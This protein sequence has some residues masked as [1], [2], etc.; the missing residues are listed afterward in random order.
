MICIY[1]IT[2]A[3]FL[4]FIGYSYKRFSQMRH[5]FYILFFC[6]VALNNI[7]AQI[8]P[9]T[10]KCVQNDTIR[11]EPFNN[12]CGAFQR[13]LIYGSMSKDGPY[14]Q[15]ASITNFTVNNYF[16]NHPKNENWFYFMQS[17]YDC[18][19]QPLINSDTLDG[20]SP[21]APIIQSVSVDAKNITI[22][23]EASKDKRVSGYI[24]YKQTDFGVKPIDTV[25]SSTKFIDT[26]VNPDKKRESYYVLGINKCGG[27]SL[28]GKPHQS[29]QL[30]VLQDECERAALLRW[31][32]YKD[33]DKGI[34]KHEVWMREGNQPY[35]KVDSVSAKDTFFIYKGLKDKTKYCF[36]VKSIQKENPK[37]V[38][39]TNEVCI[40]GNVVKTTEFIVIKNLEVNKNGEASFTWIWNNDADLDSIKIKRA[41]DGGSYKEISSLPT[42]NYGAEITFSDKT[43]LDNKQLN[44][45]EIYSLDIC[46]YYTIARFPTILLEGKPLDN[47]SNNIS[48]SPHFIDE[49]S[50]EYEL[51]RVV[52]NIETKIWEAKNE[53]DFTDP[54]DPLNPDN[55]IICYYVVSY[56]YDTLPNG[57]PIR[58]RSKSNTTCVSQTAGLF[59]PNAF[60]PRGVNQEFRPLISFNDQIES[61]SLHI[62]D[63]NGAMV[64]ESSKL[65]IGWNGKVN[66]IGQELPQGNYVYSIEMKQKN[67]KASSQK[68]S[69]FLLR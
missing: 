15:I 45:Y 6:I 51:Y 28:F 37:Y 22:T 52:N 24:V 56:A 67:G 26:N 23:W 27:T 30:N 36:Y 58:V 66:N 33:W 44:F 10:L 54:F 47:R 55:A 68:G 13:F 31:N 20:S 5:I 69:V 61:Y 60:A 17:R 39:N 2:K 1:F 29:I 46:D 3:L 59:V 49:P 11:W 38:A 41:I 64:F 57:K 42:K 16:H 7:D 50:T 65:E 21:I 53:F 43:P 19:G 9:P 8:Y 4:P 18:P 14:V 34:K 63:K 32:R 40:D 48:W 62:F 12:T 25:Y 35:I